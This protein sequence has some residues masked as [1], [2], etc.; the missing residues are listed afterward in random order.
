VL[1]VKE[2]LIALLIANFYRPYYRRGKKTD[3]INEVYVFGNDKDCP[4]TIYDVAKLSN[5]DSYEMTCHIGYR[6]NRTYINR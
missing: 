6:I 2:S 5:I 1:Y 4:Q 3:K